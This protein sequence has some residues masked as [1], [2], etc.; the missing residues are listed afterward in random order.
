MDGV[1]G[2][3]MLAAHTERHVAQIE[4]VKQSPGYPQR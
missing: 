3:L 2:M 4:E 1:Q